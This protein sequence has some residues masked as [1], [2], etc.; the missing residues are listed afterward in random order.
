M[1]LWDQQNWIDKMKKF[2]VLYWDFNDA[3]PSSYDVLPYFREEYEKLKE[4]HR[5]KTKE[6][7]EVF[8]SQRGMMRYWARA[9]YEVIIKQ[10]PPTDKAYKLD[11]WQQIKANL[12]LIVEILMQEYESNS[13][14]NSK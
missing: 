2:N 6:E 5:P 11:I 8:V 3:N 4:A 12:D 7:W 13:K 10:W 1:L 9:E 14:S